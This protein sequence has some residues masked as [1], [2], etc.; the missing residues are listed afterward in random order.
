MYRYF[1]LILMLY[2]TGVRAQPAACYRVVASDN[3]LWQERSTIFILWR[4]HSDSFEL[5]NFTSQGATVQGIKRHQELFIP[6]QT[7]TIVPFGGDC[8]AQW[9]ISVSGYGSLND[10]NLVLHFFLQRD[11]FQTK[12]MIRAIPCSAPGK[13]KKH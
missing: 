10:T 5:T 2:A 7:K 4:Q 8:N 6:E 1:F 13:R 11:T 9:D 12:G 3:P